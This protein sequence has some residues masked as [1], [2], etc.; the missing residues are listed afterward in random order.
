MD[1]PDEPETLLGSF[2]RETAVSRDE[3]QWF[4]TGHRL[5]EAL[6][7]L[8]RDG[9]SGRAAS[10]RRTWAPRR[11]G[12]HVRFELK[13]GSDAD[14]TPGARVGSRQASRYLDGAPIAALVELD[15][16]RLVTGGAARL[17]EEAEGAEEARTGA[18]PATML[19]GAREAAES[20]AE[21]EL[22]R[23]KGQA[24]T[25]LEV[26]AASEEERLV[27]AAF[28]GGAG[29]KA[30]HRALERLREHRAVTARSI[31]RVKLT[32]DAVAVVIP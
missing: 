19:E 3:L 5:V 8:V 4:A 7:G 28:A 9:D 25:R 14:T 6:L 10:V 30:I 20:A 2:W 12:L 24:L 15:A 21:D 13:W 18:V 26:H 27:E 16:G 31:E 22:A 32:L 29:K 1:I 11:G 23:R 17:E